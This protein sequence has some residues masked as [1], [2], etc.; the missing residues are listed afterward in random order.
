M[1]SH[2]WGLSEGK[3]TFYFQNCLT[4]WEIKEVL[5]EGK[6]LIMI[7]YRIGLRKPSFQAGE[8]QGRFLACTED[9]GIWNI[10]FYYAHI[11]PSFHPPSC[12]Y[13]YLGGPP[14][15]NFLRAL[16]YVGKTGFLVGRAGD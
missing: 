6:L 13:V 5:E 14:D 16:W 3:Q 10:T 15:S 8:G 11:Q 2:T 7:A 12:F 4:C 9:T 1:W